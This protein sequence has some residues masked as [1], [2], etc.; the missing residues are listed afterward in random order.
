M[1]AIEVEADGFLYNMVRNIVGSLVQIGSGK[2]QVQWIKTVLAA[3]DRTKAGPTSTS[4]DVP[5]EC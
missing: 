4:H 5:N 1:I 2:E 3:R